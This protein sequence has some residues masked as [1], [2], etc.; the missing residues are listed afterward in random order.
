MG[1][2]LP[3]PPDSVGPLP[4][5]LP[6]YLIADKN[7]LRSDR[8]VSGWTVSSFLRRSASSGLERVHRLSL[9]RRLLHPLSLFAPSLNNFGFRE[10]RRQC[11]LRL[12]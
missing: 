8:H 3:Q 5:I 11:G 9:V 10:G 1:R 6:S 12:A 2:A 4:L 7:T